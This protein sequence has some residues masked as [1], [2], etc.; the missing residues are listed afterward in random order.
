M[1]YKIYD[2][3]NG[4]KDMRKNKVIV[5]ELHLYLS[6]DSAVSFSC[7]F[8]ANFLNE[9]QVCTVIPAYISFVED[10]GMCFEYCFY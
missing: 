1:N 5:T 10:P 9:N 3:V 7:P 4:V 8:F 2:Y 6:I